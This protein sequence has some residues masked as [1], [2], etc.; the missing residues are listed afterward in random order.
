MS[1]TLRVAQPAL[2][3]PGVRLRCSSPSART[4]SL[5]TSQKCAVPPGEYLAEPGIPSESQVSQSIAL[6]HS[7][8][9]I[10]ILPNTLLFLPFKMV[11]KA[12][13]L[14]P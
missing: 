3:P 12:V 2:K 4:A 13:R 14:S 6:S 8:M 1:R 10:W 7:T 11:V 9:A 5:K